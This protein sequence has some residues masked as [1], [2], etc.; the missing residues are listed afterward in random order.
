MILILLGA[1]I[2]LALLF[3]LLLVVLPVVLVNAGLR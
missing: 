1:L 2:Y 3:E